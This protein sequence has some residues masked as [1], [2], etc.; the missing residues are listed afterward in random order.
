MRQSTFTEVETMLRRPLRY[1]LLGPVLVLALAGCQE[2]VIEEKTYTDVFYQGEALSGVDFLWIL[3]NSGTMSGEQSRLTSSI[4]GIMTLFE[5]SV[6]DYRLGVITTDIEDEEHRGKLQGEP[7]VLGPDT[8]SLTEAFLAN[9]AVGTEGSRKEQG[10]EA[11]RLAMTDALD[12]GSN[13]GFFRYEAALQVVIVS[14]E[15]DHG[16]D[17][18]TDVVVALNDLVPDPAQ[19]SIHAVVGD[20]PTGCLAP[21]ASAEAGLRYLEA[22]RLT[23]GFNGSICLDDW[24]D[25]LE[26]IGLAALGL[27]NSFVLTYE[28]DLDSLEVTVDEVVIPQRAVDGWQYDPGE[29]SI[30]FTRYA[31]PR[32]GMEVVASYHRK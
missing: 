23:E 13:E 4:D 9:A 31:I 21:D 19:F 6:A 25:L 5:E 27:V 12:D 24:T 8:P 15:D 2:Y 3:D 11:L 14:D 28:P 29:N 17:L 32:A 20:E 18:V 22:A 1:G 16:E 7:T 30:R 26:G 10:F